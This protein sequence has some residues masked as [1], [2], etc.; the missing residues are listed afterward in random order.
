M[1]KKETGPNE[2]A[3]DPSRYIWLPAFFFIVV[4]L[5]CQAGDNPSDTPPVTGSLSEI[6]GAIGARCCETLPECEWGAECDLI[7]LGT[8]RASVRGTIC[9]NRSECIGNLTCEGKSCCAS[10][11]NTCASSFDCCDDLMCTGNRCVRPSRSC[12]RT[13]QRCCEDSQCASGNGCEDERCSACGSPGEPCCFAESTLENAGR[14]GGCKAG[15]FCAG[16]FCV[17]LFRCG[18]EGEPCCPSQGNYSFPGSSFQSSSFGTC[19]DGLVCGASN[20][21]VGALTRCEG[22]SCV[23]CRARPGCGYCESSGCKPGDPSGPEDSGPEDASCSGE[24]IWNALE[25]PGSEQ[26]DIRGKCTALNAFDCQREEG[27]GW[28]GSAYV[29]SCRP[30]DRNRPNE[31]LCPDQCWTFRASPPE[32]CDL[33]FWDECARLSPSECLNDGDCVWCGN[34]K[35]GTCREG[36]S[37]GPRHGTCCWTYSGTIEGCDLGVPGVS[38]PELIPVNPDDLPPLGGS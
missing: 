17:D 28:C 2:Q 34:D 37:E 19:R 4:L 10:E 13:G 15:A 9:N 14:T 24:W 29:G 16:S 8:C 6:C 27:C 18:G 1:K 33:G 36:N 23:E 26:N 30:G 31:G 38:D 20:Q 7:G 25:C 21:C 3:K 32:Q 5:A 22:L 35:V 12:G 11:G